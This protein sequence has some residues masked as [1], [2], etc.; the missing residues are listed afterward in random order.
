[1]PDTT[2]A[3]GTLSAA[4][5]GYSYPCVAYDFQVGREVSF[6]NMAGVETLI[7][8]QLASYDLERVKDGLSNVLFWGFYRSSGRRDD[9]VK[10]FRASVTSEKLGLTIEAMSSLRGCAIGEL[11]R[12]RLPQFANLSFLSKL[13][14]FLDPSAFCVVDLKLRTIPII[15]QTFKVYHAS[16]PTY[17]PVTQANEEA[18]MWWV[19]VCR[20]VAA[21]VESAGAVRPVDAERGFFQMVEL[22]KTDLADRL[23]RQFQGDIEIGRSGR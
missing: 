15:A 11:K 13:R 17:I 12:L 21:A 9:R 14:T 18:Y 16:K 20:K 7:A 8:E 1:M 4:I 22:G 10:K 2:S 19:S 3:L 6:R 23:I 5:D